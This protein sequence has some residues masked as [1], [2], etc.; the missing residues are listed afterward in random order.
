MAK[1]IPMNQI[2]ES[3]DFTGALPT[4]SFWDYWF[5]VRSTVRP[6]KRT[7]DEHRIWERAL[8]L[9]VLSMKGTKV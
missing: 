3:H 6:A 8:N 4:T 1:S 5:A 9:G 7:L 2:E